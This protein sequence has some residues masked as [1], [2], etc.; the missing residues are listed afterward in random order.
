MNLKNKLS[1]IV[2]VSSLAFSGCGEY[3]EGRE[4]ISYFTPVIIPVVVARYEKFTDED[5]SEIESEKRMSASVS[6]FG[7]QIDME[8][9]GPKRTFLGMTKTRVSRGGDEIKIRTEIYDENRKLLYTTDEMPDSYSDFSGT[10]EFT[11]P[12]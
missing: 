5:S 8:N 4:K 2:L 7:A 11:L 3:R 12:R 6:I 10:K 1:K 9:Y